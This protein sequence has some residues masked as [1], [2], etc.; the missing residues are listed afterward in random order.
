MK[1]ISLALLAIGLVAC[2]HFPVRANLIV[3]DFSGNTFIAGSGS[4]C[5]EAIESAIIP[6]N[7]KEMECSF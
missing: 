3:T 1:L 5:S 2:S 7:W 6:E 4:T